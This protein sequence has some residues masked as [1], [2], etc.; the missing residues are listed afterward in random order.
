[1]SD[2]KS[3]IYVAFFYVLIP[4][5]VELMGLEDGALGFLACI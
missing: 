2:D 5:F 3:R 1:M 4:W